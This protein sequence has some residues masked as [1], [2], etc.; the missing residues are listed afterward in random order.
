M[1]SRFSPNILLHPWQRLQMVSSH[2]YHYIYYYSLYNREFC[3]LSLSLPLFMGVEFFS[4]ISHDA[5]FTSVFNSLVHHYG[6]MPLIV[7][8]L[9]WVENDWK[10]CATQLLKDVGLISSKVQCNSYG[11]DMTWHADPRNL[12]LFVPGRQRHLA[13]Q[14]CHWP[15]DHLFYSEHL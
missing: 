15:L 7:S 11:L 14:V 5:T 2:L 1:G 8:V 6:F 12:Q 9:L 3:F 4:I 10:Y 13:T